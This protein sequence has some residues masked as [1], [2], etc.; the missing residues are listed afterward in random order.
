M[1]QGLITFSRVTVYLAGIAVLAMCLILF[2]ELAREESVEHPDTAYLTHY[3]LAGAY[4]IT[5]PVFVAL[6]QT[7]R[8]LGYMEERKAFSG[9]SVKTLENI[10]LC[11]ITFGA[12]IILAAAA[13][14]IVARSINPTEDVTHIVALGAIFTFA[15]SVIAT[16][17]AVLQ[18]LLKNAIEMKAENDLIV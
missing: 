18:K 13:G 1:N 14:I 11:A 9:Q 8:F 7:L 4:V 10:K 15:A 17:A 12:L 6:H 3:F 2:P 5:V 16:F